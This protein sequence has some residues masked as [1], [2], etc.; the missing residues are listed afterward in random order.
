[1]YPPLQVLL[2]Q[3]SDRYTSTHHTII[4]YMYH[5]IPLYNRSKRGGHCWRDTEDK[6]STWGAGIQRSDRWG[7]HRGG[8]LECC[9]YRSQVRKVTNLRSERSPIS[10]QKGHQS[11]VRKVTYIRSE[12]SPISVQKGH[13][14]ESSVQ[15]VHFSSSSIQSSGQENHRA[16]Q[17][18]TL[19]Q[20]SMQTEDK[21][22]KLM[23]RAF[24]QFLFE[25]AIL[26]NKF[27]VAGKTFLSSLWGWKLWVRGG[28]RR[29][30]VLGL[31]GCIH[32]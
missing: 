18:K 20:M 23:F 9:Q 31:I 21:K 12:M 22:T 16:K 30:H 10:S 7:H 15:T 32:V 26:V 29:G 24:N 17:D 3:I 27:E 5:R 25:E 13:I 8:R 1:M 11:Q 2:D 14:L 6:A 19:V 28:Y 4:V